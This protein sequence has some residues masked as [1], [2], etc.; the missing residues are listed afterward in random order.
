[1]QIAMAAA[2]A[3]ARTSFRSVVD[4]Q[5]KDITHLMEGIS[6]HRGLGHFLESWGVVQCGVI[7][8]M[9][10]QVL[11]AQDWLEVPAKE[12]VKVAGQLIR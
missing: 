6:P 5:G 10:S 7:A 2:L 11:L 12:V 1:M 4:T 9:L 3:R 8:A